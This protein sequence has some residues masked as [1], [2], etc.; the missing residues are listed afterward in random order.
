MGYPSW[1]LAVGPV[2][3]VPQAGLKL[4]GIYTVDA[5]ARRKDPVQPLRNGLLVASTVLLGV[6][7]LAIEVQPSQNASQSRYPHSTGP[8]Q[9]P[10]LVGDDQSAG[11]HHGHN[12]DDQQCV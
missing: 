6:T 8:L 4:G 3:Q 2:P 11:D 12:Q 5:A 10:Q 9:A 7:I 1:L